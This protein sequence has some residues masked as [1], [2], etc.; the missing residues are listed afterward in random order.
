[1]W[2]SR[3]IRRRTPQT[4]VPTVTWTSRAKTAAELAAATVTANREL[5]LQQAAA[6]LGANTTYLAIANP[7]TNQAVT[8]VRA[9]TVQVNKLI[10]LAAN[11]LDSVD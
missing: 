9:L 11:L 10:R 2:C 3:R 4:G 6:A 5:L 1:M 7:T 8:Q